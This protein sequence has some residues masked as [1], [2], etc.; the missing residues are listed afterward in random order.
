MIKKN[1]GEKME[2][3][4]FQIKERLAN[5]SISV[6]MPVSE[7]T[8]VKGFLDKCKT[9]GLK[10]NFGP[11]LL[12]FVRRAEDFLKK[13]PELEDKPAESAKIDKPAEKNI[14]E[15]KINGIINKADQDPAK[16]QV[17]NEEVKIDETDETKQNK[18]VDGENKKNKKKSLFGRS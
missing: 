2:N 10:P 18:E 12:K 17:Q 11:V 8:E 7:V 13:H 4:Y 3:Q 15:N 1:I 6:R 9:I 14:A 5:V 16:D